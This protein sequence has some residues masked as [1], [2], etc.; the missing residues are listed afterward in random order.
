MEKFRF[1]Y[2]TVWEYRRKKNCIFI[3]FDIREFYPS[4]TE[5][6]LDKALLFEK[7]HHDISNDNTRLIKHCH[8][9]LLFSESFDVAEVCELAGIYIFRF[10]AKLI[11]KNDCGLYRDDGLLILWNV[12]GQQID[13]VH[14]KIIKIF[15]DIGFAIDVETNLKIVDI[16]GITFDLNNG[17]YMCAIFKLNVMPIDPTKSQTIYYHI[18]IDLQIIWQKLPINYQ[19]QLMKVYPEIPPMKKALIHLN[20]NTKLQIQI[21][22]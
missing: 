6:T 1:C 12:N 15:K 21:K 20:I 3:K 8:K 9:S 7:Q 18:L 19:Q 22:A 14:K 11:N 10:L 2:R 17:T 13:R 16:F 5:T 4:I